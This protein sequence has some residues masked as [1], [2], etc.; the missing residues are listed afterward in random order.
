MTTDTI[1]TATE[2]TSLE[3]K[4]ELGSEQG[5]VCTSIQRSSSSAGPP[6]GKHCFQC[7]GKDGKLWTRS[8]LGKEVGLPHSEPAEVIPESPCLWPSRK[9]K[10]GFP[11]RKASSFID[12]GVLQFRMRQI[13]ESIRRT[14]R[15]METRHFRMKVIHM[16][17]L[18]TEDTHQDWF[19][20]INPTSSLPKRR[21]AYLASRF[22]LL[23]FLQFGG[24]R[25]HL[26]LELG[27]RDLS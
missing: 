4:W 22:C 12:E 7:H 17:K 21:W 9:A 15:V 24:M 26:S 25:G 3:L 16:C 11:W 14:R 19:R 8:H 10:E 23:L 13:F 18:M 2:I 1:A 20:E 27:L 6:K 5:R